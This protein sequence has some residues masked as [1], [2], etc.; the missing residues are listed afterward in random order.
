L[1]IAAKISCVVI[2]GLIAI[3]SDALD[4]EYPIA[5]AQMHKHSLQLRSTNHEFCVGAIH[6]SHAIHFLK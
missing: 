2:E 3:Q 4:F 5:R 1:A 6:K